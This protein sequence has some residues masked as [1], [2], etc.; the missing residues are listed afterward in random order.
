MSI[1]VRAGLALRF[2][3]ET[4]F[5]SIRTVADGLHLRFPI[6]VRDM[7]GIL[8][9]IKL[10]SQL[11]S[12]TCSGSCEI[13]ISNDGLVHYTGSV[14]NSGG[15]A[16]TYAV[17]TSFPTITDHTSFPPDISNL[18]GILGPV[19]ITHQ[20]HVGGTL[21]FDVRDSTWD[22]TATVARIAANWIAVKVAVTSARTVFDTDTSA[23]ELI[24]GVV[25]GA[26]GIF[27]LNL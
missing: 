19:V 27:V 8:E 10:T 15:L 7:V 13:I 18:V 16:A 9:P 11:N 12:R 17:M 6:A 22:K 26:S 5:S 21:S 25:A 3:Q 14:H 20:G 2:S 1:S 23:T 4:A 24:D